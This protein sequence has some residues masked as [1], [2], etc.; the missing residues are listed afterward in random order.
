MFDV[1]GSQI[2]LTRGNTAVLDIL[3]W[4]DTPD[5]PLFLEEKDKVLFTVRHPF[6]KI[7]FQKV[8]TKSDQ[9]EDGYIKLVI[10]PEDTVDMVSAEYNYD[11]MIIFED[12]ESY[13]FIP[14]SIFQIL[15]AIGSYKDLEGDDE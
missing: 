10:T 12:G 14:K 11:V 8:L 5:E 6:G 15:P 13:T 1:T 4:T 7:V 2:S 3:P 9:E